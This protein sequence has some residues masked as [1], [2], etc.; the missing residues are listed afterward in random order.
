LTAWSYPLRVIG[1]NS[2]AAYCIAHLFEGF[3]VSS[4]KTHLGDHV[5]SFAGPE[6]A[7]LVEGI[8]VLAVYWLILFW[9]F[10]RRIFLRL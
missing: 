3:I 8:A 7:P 2:I 9:M 4:F 6:Y 5:F 10:R 1:A